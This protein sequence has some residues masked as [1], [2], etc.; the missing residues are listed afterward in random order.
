MARIRQD[1][2]AAVLIKPVSER[3]LQSAVRDAMRPAPAFA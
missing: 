1:H 3:Q 2:P